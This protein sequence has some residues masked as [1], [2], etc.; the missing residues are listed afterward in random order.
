[1]NKFKAISFLLSF[2]FMLACSTAQI[3][4]NPQMANAYYKIGVAYLNENKIQ[5]AFVEFQKAYEIN[6]HD[7]EVL[8]AIGIIYLLHF[9][10]LQ[11]AAEY[12]EKAV[13]VDSDYS[14]AYNN[15][16]VAHQKMEHF[17]TAISFY[18]KALLNLMSR[19]PENAYINMGTSY[20]RLKNYE[21][22]IN[23]FK[24]AIK[25]APDLSL[26]YFRLALC[27][28]AMGKYG[29]ASA[30]ISHAVTLDPVYQG[31]R[32]KALEDLSLKK[33]KATGYDEQDIND[34]LE[35]L[36]Y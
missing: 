29:D 4:K 19:T 17:E 21:S 22:A 6:P 1:M 10:E 5:Q 8:N 26:A 28:N 33:F 12:F 13:K 14:E 15:L 32:E 20:Y 3:E 36:K 7:K 16:G 18:K 23:S 27:Y 35:I 25:R 2:C 34:Y 30:S 11:K 9:D 31:S 24:E